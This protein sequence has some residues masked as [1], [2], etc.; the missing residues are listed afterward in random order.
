[1]S[2]SPLSSDQVCAGIEI[3]STSS[4]PRPLQDAGNARQCKIFS[5]NFGP[6]DKNARFV[7]IRT[8]QMCPLLDLLG[9][10]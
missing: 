5:L 6:R 4:V 9:F 1:M 2:I 8:F 7:K 3:E 10:F